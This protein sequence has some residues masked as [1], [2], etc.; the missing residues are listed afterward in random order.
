MV[1][2]SV[3]LQI[4]EQKLQDLLYSR[5]KHIKSKSS[6]VEI[7]IC[8]AG[9]LVSLFLSDF[10]HL[11]LYSKIGLIAASVI[12]LAAFCLSLYGTNYSVEAFYKDICDV[13]EKDHSFSLLVLRD[14]SGLFPSQYA[15]RYDRRWR[16][17]LFPYIRTRGN[18]M[19]SVKEYVSGMGI[20]DFKI[21]RTAEQDFTKRSVSANMSKTYHHTFYLVSFDA[22]KT[23]ARKRTFRANREKFRW[24]STN[25]MKADRRMN[26]RNSENIVYVEKTF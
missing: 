23:S 7:I 8:L 17:W 26:E 2:N 18:D 1:Y 11:P 22:S 13:A 5:K 19:E 10:Q 25:E 12:Y 21:E 4:E 15:L 14:S 6:F 9:F 16:C 24:Y 3:M 20:Q